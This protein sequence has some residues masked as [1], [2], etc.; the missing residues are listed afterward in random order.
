MHLWLNI[1]SHT[2]N[3]LSGCYWFV[4]FLKL[5]SFFMFIYLKRKRGQVGEGQRERGQR[6][7]AVSTESAMGLHP[8]HCEMVTWVKI[9]SWTL[10]PVSHP[11]TSSTALRIGQVLLVQTP[12]MEKNLCNSFIKQICQMPAHCMSL[13]SEERRFIG[14]TGASQKKVLV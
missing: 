3:L 10:N 14:S 13:G 2:K 9:K 11:D 4:G 6:I 5:C 7:R 12:Y 1:H 8:T